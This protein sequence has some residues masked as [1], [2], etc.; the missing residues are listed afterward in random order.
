MKAK[1]EAPTI[2][3]VALHTKHLVSISQATQ[4]V[5]TDD[6]QNVSNA[7]VKES[8]SENIWDGEW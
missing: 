4:N 7:M 2:I 5:Y 1:Y 3:Q 8:S 6:A